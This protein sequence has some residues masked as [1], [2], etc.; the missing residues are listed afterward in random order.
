MANKR[1][2]KYFKVDYIP[3]AR[4]RRAVKDFAFLVRNQV[5]EGG[6]RLGDLQLTYSE[7]GKPSFVLH[8]EDLA[9]SDVENVKGVILSKEDTRPPEPDEDE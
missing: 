8:T 2:P 9:E 3:E 5:L 7:T 1:T 6:L 4:G